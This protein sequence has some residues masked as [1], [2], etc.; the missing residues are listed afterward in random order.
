MTSHHSHMDVAHTNV[1]ISPFSGS[2]HMRN[3]WMTLHLYKTSLITH[4]ILKYQQVNCILAQWN[5]ATYCDMFGYIRIY[6]YSVHY[7]LIFI[8]VNLG[9]I[10]IHAITKSFR[11]RLMLLY[12]KYWITLYWLQSFCLNLVIHMSS[13][14]DHFS[15]W[16]KKGLEELY[17]I[18]ISHVTIAIFPVALLKFPTVCSKHVLLLC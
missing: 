9:A 14:L 16:I 11:D 6:I 15:L 4:G 3:N 5:K 1:I 2:C 17:S 7:L 13:C 18:H 10:L 12:I 8:H